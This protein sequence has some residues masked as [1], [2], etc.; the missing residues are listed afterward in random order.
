MHAS[1]ACASCWHV[2]VPLCPALQ[3]IIS[4]SNY[5]ETFVH[6]VVHIACCLVLFVVAC[7]PLS[8]CVCCCVQS[9]A[10]QAFPELIVLACEVKVCA[11]RGVHLLKVYGRYRWLGKLLACSR[12][13]KIT[14]KYEQ[15]IL[16]MVNI[17]PG[18]VSHRSISP[19]G[20]SHPSRHASL[21]DNSSRQ[22]SQ[23]ES[24]F[25]VSPRPSMAAFSRPASA[26][27]RA[28]NSTGQGLSNS[29]GGGNSSHHGPAFKGM[30]V[31]EGKYERVYSIS[32]AVAFGEENAAAGCYSRNNSSSGGGGWSQGVHN[33]FG[34][35]KSGSIWWALSSSLEFYSGATQCTANFPV[36]K[37]GHCLS[38]VAVDRWGNVWCG[39]TK[40]SLLVRQRHQWERVRSSACINTDCT[41]DHGLALDYAYRLDCWSGHSCGGEVH[42]AVIWQHTCADGVVM[43]QPRDGDTL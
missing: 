29:S 22:T 27:E 9:V 6:A 5:L 1:A 8:G 17:M 14:M 15:A 21:S 41:K 28:M 13:E 31:R 19:F 2:S 30:A 23:H 32:Q 4:D 36:E 18:M 33:A 34:Y 20:L 10:A 12:R 24:P 39:T 7:R 42:L 43:Q 3:S 16:R 26:F 11:K 35:G 37:K 40:G 38:C 25:S